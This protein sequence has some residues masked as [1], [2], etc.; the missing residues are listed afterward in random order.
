MAGM[1]MPRLRIAMRVD[2]V[3]GELVR[4]ER[5]SRSDAPQCYSLSV[6]LRDQLHDNR[7]S[8]SR[9]AMD[10]GG[11]MKRADMVRYMIGT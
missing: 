2:A 9:T 10:V 6:R 3:A 11:R 4:G 8:G 5:R 7:Q 1:A